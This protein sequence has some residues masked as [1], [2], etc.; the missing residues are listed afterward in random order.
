MLPTK[1]QKP[2]TDPMQYT[3]LI[4]GPTKVG[5]TT[6][7]SNA[8]G[9]L[10]LATEPGTNAL[11]V[12]SLAIKTWQDLLAA[13][14]ELAKGKHGFKTIVI[15]TI[16]NAYL[17]C[18]EH[19]C[20]ENGWKHPSDGAYGK[21]FAAVNN[22]FRRVMLK[23]ANMPM[24]LVVISHSQEKDV[25]TRTG[26]YTRIT[27]TLPGGANKI[28][29]GLMDMVLYAEVMA[30]KEG[31]ELAYRR[32]FRT[33]QTPAYD[34]GDRTGKLPETLPLDWAAFIAAFEGDK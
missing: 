6:F 5:K 1:K 32:V 24:G 28:V 2:L 7:A 13:C 26:T 27:T 8:P 25:E 34:A 16:D 4:Y 15:D 29:L 9:A 31:K 10:F 19:V 20:K 33:K 18:Q 23:L 3:T 17:F 22:E 11:E 21:G 30:V 14:A 12:Y